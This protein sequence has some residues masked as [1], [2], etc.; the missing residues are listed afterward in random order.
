MISIA[1][2]ITSLPMGSFS[3]LISIY[4]LGRVAEDIFSFNGEG[5]FQ[6]NGVGGTYLVNASAPSFWYLL[7]Q[8]NPLAPRNTVT[9]RLMI[10]CVQNAT[11]RRQTKRRSGEHQAIDES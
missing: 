9:D 11:K 8:P 3:I 7:Y 1:H 10:E 2:S 5:D 6:L 4:T